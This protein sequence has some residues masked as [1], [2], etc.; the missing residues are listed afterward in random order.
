MSLKKNENRLRGDVP[1]F[2]W[3][4]SRPYYKHIKIWGVWF[5]I[6]NGNIKINNL[7][8]RSHQAYFIGYAATTGVII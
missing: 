1:Y 2:L 6:I 5:Y 3:N 7:E 4:S 8:I